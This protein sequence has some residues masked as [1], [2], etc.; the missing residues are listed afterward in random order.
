MCV[1]VGG[2]VMLFLSAFLFLL[3]YCCFFNLF[4]I[5]GYFYWGAGGGVEML[6]FVFF[7]GVGGEYARFQALGTLLFQ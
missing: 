5:Y 2:W 1:C 4:F 6:C 3:G 7:F